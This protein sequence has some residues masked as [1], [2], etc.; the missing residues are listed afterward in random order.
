MEGHPCEPKE[1]VVMKHKGHWKLLYK[2]N[3]KQGIKEAIYTHFSKAYFGHG[4]KKYTE[5]K[6]LMY[7]KSASEDLV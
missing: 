2:R 6:L 1:T 4:F 7:C 5:S 3:L